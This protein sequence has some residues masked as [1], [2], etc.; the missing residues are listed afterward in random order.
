MNQK[1]IAK[2]SFDSGLQIVTP[3]RIPTLFPNHAQKAMGNT[4]L[5][6]R[7]SV[8]TAEGVEDAQVRVLETREIQFR[9]RADVSWQSR[10]ILPKGTFV[11]GAGRLR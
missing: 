3:S 5:V 11:S 1:V 9:H 7:H 6:R 8:G 4:P 10:G 2:N